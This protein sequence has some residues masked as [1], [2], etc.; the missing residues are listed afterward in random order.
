MVCLFSCSAQY[1]FSFPFSTWLELPWLLPAEITPNA[2]R[3]NANAMSTM[4]NWLWNFAVVMWTPPM[5]TALGGFGTFLFFGIVNAC[6]FPVIWLFYVETKGRTLE[7][8]D[9]IFAKAYTNKEWYVKVGNEMP[10]LSTD[11]VEREAIK[12]GLTG[13]LEHRV[14]SAAPSVWEDQGEKGKQQESEQSSATARV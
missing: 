1:R 2:I 10:R 11:E 5:L 12:W 6:F 13:D 14:G 8:I 7:E 9:I 4:T 3:T